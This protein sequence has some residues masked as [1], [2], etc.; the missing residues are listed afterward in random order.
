M[1][2]TD[3]ILEQ[4]FTEAMARSHGFEQLPSHQPDLAL[5]VRGL[6]GEK[7]HFVLTYNLTVRCLTT[8]RKL[9]E[10]LVRPRGRQLDA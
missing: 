8:S 3:P 4:V 1:N 10:S 6:P 9:A 5:Y 7:L 2:D